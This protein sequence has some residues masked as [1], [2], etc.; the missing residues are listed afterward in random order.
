MQLS[1]LLVSIIPEDPLY[2]MKGEK[3][4]SQLSCVIQ[5]EEAT[6]FQ[7]ARLMQQRQ[8]AAKVDTSNADGLLTV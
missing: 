1:A 8:T 4:V 2:D 5:K 7:M 3:K 6:A